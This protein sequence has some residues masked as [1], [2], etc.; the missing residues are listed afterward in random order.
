ML[1][2]I[3]RLKKKQDI[4]KVF[5]KGKKIKE[6]LLVL[7][8]AKNNLSQTRFG[9]IVSKK[10]SKKATIRN[11]IK[12]RLREIAGKKRKRVKKGLDVLLIAPP[13]LETKDFWEIDEMLNKIFTKA[14]IL[15]IQKSSLKNQK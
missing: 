15:K 6:G 2:R 5:K 13:G 11:K 7:K 8:M 1:P 10:V 14:K 4:K 9:F 12:R 3:N